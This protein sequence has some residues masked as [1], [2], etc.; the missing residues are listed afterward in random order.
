MTERES[1]NNISNRL[2]ENLVKA[3][4]M[5]CKKNVLLINPLSAR[6]PAGFK[7]GREMFPE[8]RVC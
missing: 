3:S 2:S 1:G 6:P 8:L 4:P 7:Y 5:V